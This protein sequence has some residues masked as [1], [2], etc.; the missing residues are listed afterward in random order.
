MIPFPWGFQW[1]LDRPRSGLGN[2]CL[3]DKNV[4][5]KEGHGN[6]EALT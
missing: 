4:C 3:T 6:G 2:H 5:R 1:W